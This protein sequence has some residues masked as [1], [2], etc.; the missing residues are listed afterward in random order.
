LAQL[1]GLEAH[2][3]DLEAA[4]ED[5]DAEL[6]RLLAHLY[7]APAAGPEVDVADCFIC[8]WRGASYTLDGPDARRD[9]C[10]PDCAEALDDHARAARGR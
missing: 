9:A 2:L 4:V 7:P 3:R 1:H 8:D 5:D 10:S 6:V